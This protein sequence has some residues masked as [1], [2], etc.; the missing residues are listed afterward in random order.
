MPETLRAKIQQGQ[1]SLGSWLQLPSPDTAE[2]MAHMGYDWL[3]IDMEH[4]SIDISQL[5][6]ILRAIQGACLGKN[7]REL[8]ESGAPHTSCAPQALVRVP[9]AEKMA[10]RRA[11]DA[12]AQGIILPMI[13]S[14]A[15]LNEALDVALYPHSQ[16]AQGSR[17]VGYARANMYGHY[18]QSYMQHHEE[19]LVFVA[20]IEHVDALHDLENIVQ[21]PRLD[22]IM[23]GPYDL[24]AS[25]GLMGKFDH[26][27][28]IQAMEEI[29]HICQKHSMPMG[30]H[31]VQPDAKALSAAVAQGYTFIAYGIDALFLHNAAHCP[32][33]SF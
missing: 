23:V 26:P 16:K 2:I 12:G 33:F 4:G 17:G 27:L 15:Q 6:N 10:I 31:V 24:S 22:A 9:T 7:S 18:F 11:L 5:P 28:F 19:E 13:Q 8:R 20:Q 30:S 21:H 1:T 32:V 14:R 25:M 29:Q 3:V